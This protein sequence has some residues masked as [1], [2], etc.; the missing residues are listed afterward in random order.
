MDETGGP[1]TISFPDGGSPPPGGG[2]GGADTGVTHTLL[3]GDR[4]EDT[5]EATPVAG[6]LVYA[7]ATPAW[8]RLAKGTDGQFFQMVSGAP[9]WGAAPSGGSSLS[10]LGAWA[11]GDASALTGS[12]ATLKNTWTKGTTDEIPQVMPAAGQVDYISVGADGDIGGVGDSVYVQLYKETG[13]VGSGFSATGLIVQLLGGTGDERFAYSSTGGPVSF[14]AGDR[15]ELRGLKNG[16]PGAREIT[17]T[18]WGTFS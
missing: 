3:D 18:L 12:Y 4:H 13:A 7:N 16:S 9:A 2:G 6:D 1:A 17:S 11:K 10:P 8:D 15:L 14:A 5:A